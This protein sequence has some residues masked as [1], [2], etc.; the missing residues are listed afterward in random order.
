MWSSQAGAMPFANGIT[1]GGYDTGAL[2]PVVF[3]NGS[4]TIIGITLADN[5][6][7]STNYISATP[8][9]AGLFLMST[10]YI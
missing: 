9:Q 1:I 6:P 2:I 3:H 10:A 8:A 7:N 4:N 5:S